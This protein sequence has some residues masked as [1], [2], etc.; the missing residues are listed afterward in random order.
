MAYVDR[1]WI[2]GNLWRPE[3]WSV[4]RETVRTNNDV[5]GW[6]R[7]LNNR[8]NGSKLPFYVMVPLLRTEAD[9]VTLTVR[10]V[11]EQM[12]T[13]NH[14]MQY[15]KLHDKLYEIWDRYENEDEY[16]TSRLLRESSHLVGTGP[17]PANIE[18]HGEDE[19]EE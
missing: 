18:D 2:N 10:L 15:K 11:S 5:E 4:F 7:G 14:R 19:D 6:H 9:D 12:M 8:A 3:N 13:R 1:T 16:T 17:I